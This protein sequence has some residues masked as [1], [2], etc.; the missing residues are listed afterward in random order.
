MKSGSSWK[1]IKGT[2]RKCTEENRNSLGNKSSL[3]RGVHF[4]NIAGTKARNRLLEII[5]LNIVISIWGIGSLEST[6]VRSMKDNRRLKIN[7]SENW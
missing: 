3:I 6:A 7:G 2:N 4:S 1:S 5:A